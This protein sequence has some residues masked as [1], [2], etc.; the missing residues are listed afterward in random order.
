M[1]IKIKDK[2]YNDV[3]KIHNILEKLGCRNIKPLNDKFRFGLD[4]DG[5]SSGNSLDINTLH[6]HSF[7][8]NIKGDI[9]TLV[10]EVKSISLGG[11][12]RWLANE[13]GLAYEQSQKTEVVLPFGGF[14]KSY[15]KI[16]ENEDSPPLIYPIDRLNEYD[17]CAAKLFIEDNI[18]ATIQEDFNI[19]YDYETNRIL[20]PWFD[21]EGN[22]VGIMGRKNKKK[23]DPRD[24]KYLPIIPFSKSK[25]LYGFYENYNNILNNGTV[26]VCESEK[27]VMLGREYGYNNVIALGG[28]NLSDRQA[29]L[30]KSTC[31]NVIIALDEG[32][33]LAHS[34][35]LAEKCKINN[36]FFSNNTFV[37]DIEGLPEKHCIF[38]MN[39]E[40]I[41]DYLENKLIYI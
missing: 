21:C 20:L 23:L 1:I 9:F 8:R 3:D 2:L 30:I 38:D 6:F 18:S 12:I 40:V 22:L 26:I 28:N 41:E 17:I 5:S 4:D 27:S 32:I 31:C 39:K 11:S 29:K 35:E 7:S 34:V 19:R 37:L 14:F 25:V 33:G 13:L 15:E 36:P 16:K 10:S 24:T